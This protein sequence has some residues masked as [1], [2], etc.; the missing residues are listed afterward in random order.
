M[1][2]KEAIDRLRDQT[3]IPWGFV[4]FLL[5]IL[6]V[7]FLFLCTT[8]LRFLILDFV[9]VDGIDTASWMFG[10]KVFDYGLDGLIVLWVLSRQWS[11]IERF[12]SNNIVG[13]EAVLWLDKDKKL[14]I[15]VRRSFS[16]TNFNPSFLL[17]GI[18]PVLVPLGGLFSSRWGGFFP[19]DGFVDQN[20]IIRLSHIFPSSVE[21]TCRFQNGSTTLL[22]VDNILT[23]LPIISRLR[24][25][26]FGPMLAIECLYTDIRRLDVQLEESTQQC[27][28]L[29]GRYDDAL[30]ACERIGPLHVHVRVLTDELVK[31]AKFIDETSRL[32]AYMNKSVEGL[33]FLL[34]LYGRILGEYLATEKEAYWLGRVKDTQASLEKMQAKNRGRHPRLDPNVCTDDHFVR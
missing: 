28:K 5:G 21:L 3:L 16:G 9:H 11:W 25:A 10:L 12:V 19:S 26:G 7:L 8:I 29:Q 33:G 13:W 4:K 24:F 18:Y 22:H 20:W 6:G 32:S 2:G 1:V 14:N 23:V 34:M 17:D 31:L 15:D 30:K 27:D